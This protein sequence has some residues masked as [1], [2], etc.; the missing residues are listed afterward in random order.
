MKVGDRVLAIGVF[1]FMVSGC[2]TVME[3]AALIVG[4]SGSDKLPLGILIFKSFA[5]IIYAGFTIFNA[6]LCFI[7]LCNDKF[8]LLRAYNIVFC[9]FCLLLIIDGFLSLYNI[10]VASIFF[11]SA[12]IS[13]YFCV[14]TCTAKSRLDKEGERRKDTATAYHDETV[15]ITAQEHEKPKFGMQ[16]SVEKVENAAKMAEIED[17]D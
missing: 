11:S 6:C 3:M 7:K 15:Q 12:I 10:A 14:Y 1:M 2:S 16:I 17:S 9:I 8:R 5:I 4:F 13:I